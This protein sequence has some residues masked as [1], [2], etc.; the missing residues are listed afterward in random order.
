L[1]ERDL[2]GEKIG[3]QFEFGRI[4]FLECSRKL[5]GFLQLIVSLLPER[6]G[7]SRA[8]VANDGTCHR[9]GSR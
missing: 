5:F 7:I 3:W 6:R 2:Q 4:G 9:V 8:T 1:A